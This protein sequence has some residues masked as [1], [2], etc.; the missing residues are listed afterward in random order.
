MQF[1]FSHWYNYL[2]TVT[3]TQEFV[4][5][6]QITLLRTF[7]SFMKLSPKYPFPETLET[8]ALQP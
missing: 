5:G 6:Q 1:F 3:G 2:L 4:E 7:V 8:P